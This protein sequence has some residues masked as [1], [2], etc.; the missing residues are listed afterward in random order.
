[1]WCE[2]SVHVNTNV[3]TLTLALMALDDRYALAS[4]FL[5]RRHDG[6]G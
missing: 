1:M 2:Q 5:S 6:S 4:V 3:A